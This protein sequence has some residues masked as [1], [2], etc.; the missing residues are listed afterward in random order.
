MFWS[1]RK[2]KKFIK[3]EIFAHMGGECENAHTITHLI[4]PAERVN[5]QLALERLLGAAGPDARLLGY[6]AEYMSSDSGLS[7]ILAHDEQYQVGPVEREQ[8]ARGPRQELDCVTRG[9]YLLRWQD[10]PL[11]AVV[12]PADSW[13]REYLLELMAHERA[14]AQG[15]LERLL[16]EVKQQNVYR[17]RTISLEAAGRSSDSFA[18]RFH[19]LPEAARES[20]V[21]PESVLQVIERNVL[22]MLRH[23]EALRRSGRST[24][25][26]LLFHGRPGT[27]KTLVARYLARAC[28][29]HTVILMTGRQMGM[30]RESCQM[31]RLLAPSVVILEDVDLIAEDRADNKC[32]V[33]LH[34][35]LDEMDGIGPRT[36]CVFILTTNRP[37]ALETALAARPGRIDQ[38]VEFPLPDEDCRRRLF[39]LYGK[40]LDLGAVDVPRWV[41]QTQGASPAFIEELLRKAALMAAERGEA[42]EPLRVT[43]EDV[44]RAV[45]ELVL[46]GGELTQK[47][48]GFRP[49]AIG[50]RTAAT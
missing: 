14:A 40:G 35:L 24:R 47:L 45:K 39:E 21:L 22:G 26:G 20:I 28:P 12:R 6:T 43:D 27:G 36:D 19:E 50:Y 32:P 1:S 42:S 9:V 44:G 46:F 3:P 8:L 30:I 34:E 23:G 29:D 7:S 4:K 48:L 31:A 33:L 41:S 5:L 10:R 18:V 2:R 15:V 38:A 11:A 49:S 17:G 13:S 16:E 37:E 25:H